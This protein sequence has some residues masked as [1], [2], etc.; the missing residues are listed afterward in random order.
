MNH[1]QSLTIRNYLRFIFRLLGIFI[2]IFFLSDIHKIFQTWHWVVFFFGPRYG[3]IF[4]C[5][6]H[7]LT[8]VSLLSLSVVSELFKLWVLTYCSNESSNSYSNFSIVNSMHFLRPIPIF[9]NAFSS[10]LLLL[11]FITSSPHFSSSPLL[12]LPLK[13]HPFRSFYPLTLSWAALSRPGS[14]VHHGLISDQPQYHNTAT[15]HHSQPGST[16]PIL[17][18]PGPNKSAGLMVRKIIS[19]PTNNQALL[20]ISRLTNQKQLAY[21]TVTIQG[22]QSTKWLQLV[23]E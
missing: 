23:G 15:S 4:N 13:A 20:L 2:I 21:Q 1:S 11:P 19:Q 14:V 12:H 9:S 22:C 5:T 18:S 6:R 16:H 8:L 10:Y 7:D 17:P 3:T